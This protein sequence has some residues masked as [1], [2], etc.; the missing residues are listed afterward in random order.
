MKGRD[1]DLIGDTIPEFVCRNSGKLQ[2]YKSP[3]YL[4]LKLY[5]IKQEI[6]KLILFWEG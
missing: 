6:R 4:L 2:N 1:S 5:G 3:A